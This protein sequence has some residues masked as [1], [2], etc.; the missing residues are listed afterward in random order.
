VDAH[1]ALRCDIRLID[2]GFDK[3]D[4]PSRMA[5]VATAVGRVVSRL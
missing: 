4:G 5:G 1:Y 2:H 3:F